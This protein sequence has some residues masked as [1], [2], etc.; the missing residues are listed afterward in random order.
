MKIESQTATMTREK[1]RIG[2]ANGCVDADADAAV[3][4]ARLIIWQAHKLKSQ[5]Q[6]VL[7]RLI[8]DPSSIGSGF[9]LGRLK[10]AS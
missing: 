2:V 6:V 10:V 3:F 4:A 5:F 8:C 1:P 7:L 9:H